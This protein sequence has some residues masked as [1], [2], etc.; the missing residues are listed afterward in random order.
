MSHFIL[1]AT[2]LT[3]EFLYEDPCVKFD[4]FSK[5]NDLFIFLQNESFRGESVTLHWP[6]S[7]PWQTQILITHRSI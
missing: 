7:T 4:A 1:N 3:H 5:Q 2:N 6:V